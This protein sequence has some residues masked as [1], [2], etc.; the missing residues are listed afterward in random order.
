[1]AIATGERSIERRREGAG[2]N[3]VKE[4]RVEQL[5]EHAGKERQQKERIRAAIAAGDTEGPNWH[6]SSPGYF[7]IGGL[8]QP[9]RYSTK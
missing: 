7:K 5:A 9:V 4:P 8:S 2:L 3:P 1:M 6:I